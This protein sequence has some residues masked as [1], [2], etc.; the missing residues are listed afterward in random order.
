M[1][2]PQGHDRRLQW[3]YAAAGVANGDPVPESKAVDRALYAEAVGATS[4]RNTEG[5]NPLRIPALGLQ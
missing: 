1:G 4:R 3:A 5:R 2:D